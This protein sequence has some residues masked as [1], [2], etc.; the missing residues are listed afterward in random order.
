MTIL[1]AEVISKEDLGA[2]TAE[3]LRSSFER[4]LKTRT[5]NTYEMA[6]HVAEWDR[7]GVLVEAK[8]YMGPARIR[9]LLGVAAGRI[10]PAT[11]DCLPTTLAERVGGLAVSEQKRLL[12]GDPID[13]VVGR[14]PDGEPDLLKVPVED[15]TPGM[16]VQV[17]D[18][19][20]IR[21]VAA[22]ARLRN[23]GAAKQ[24]DPLEEIRL[25]FPKDVVKRL[26]AGARARRVTLEEFIRAEILGEA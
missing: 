17:F 15:L 16:A 24:E 21:D 6:L 14:K 20:V 10:L 5:Q 4:L 22:Q 26:K 8:R 2:L 7:R 1:T 23:Q 13:V 11:V 9:L 18:N 12:A 3:E 25:R 19:A